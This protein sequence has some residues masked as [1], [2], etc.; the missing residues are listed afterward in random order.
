M[1]LLEY[2]LDLDYLV[3]NGS[4][5]LLNLLGESEDVKVLCRGSIEALET[6]ADL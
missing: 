2:L 4:S 5:L 6:L 3:F 1:L